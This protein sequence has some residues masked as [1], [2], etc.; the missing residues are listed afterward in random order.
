MNRRKIPRSGLVQLIVFYAGNRKTV[1]LVC[2]N[3]RRYCAFQGLG[4]WGKVE[5]ATIAGALPATP[6]MRLPRWWVVISHIC[7]VGADLRVCPI[8]NDVCPFA[9]MCTHFATIFALFAVMCALCNDFRHFA[10]MFAKYAA[11][12]W[13]KSRQTGQTRRSAPTKTV[14]MQ[15]PYGGGVSSQTGQPSPQNG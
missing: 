5:N 4:H 13:Q 2:K 7:N 8:R 11:F 12:R 14:E 6:T 9:V 1:P 10:T 15:R 3:H